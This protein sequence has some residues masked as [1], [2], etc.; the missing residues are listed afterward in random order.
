MIVTVSFPDGLTGRM[1]VNQVNELLGPYCQ[2]VNPP[3][4]PDDPGGGP[5]TVS[6]ELNYATAVALQKAYSIPL[7]EVVRRVLAANAKPNSRS[8][9]V[10]PDAV[11]STPT[12]PVP[13]SAKPSSLPPIFAVLLAMLLPLALIV[14]AVILLRR[15]PASRGGDGFDEWPG[16]A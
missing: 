13:Q 9:R 6:V 1:P 7:N 16:G 5:E 10:M 12:N 8:Q 15:F 2:G 14:G 3:R 11:Q 4:L